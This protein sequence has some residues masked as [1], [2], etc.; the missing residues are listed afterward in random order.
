MIKNSILKYSNLS[1]FDQRE[2]VFKSIKKINIKTPKLFKSTKFFGKKNEETKENIMNLFCKTMSS[3]YSLDKSSS[4]L[5]LLDYFENDKQKKSNI[6]HKFKSIKRNSNIKNEIENNNNKT[7]KINKTSNNFYLTE[8]SPI[9]SRNKPKIKKLSEL[10]NQEKGQKDDLNIDKLLLIKTYRNNENNKMKISDCSDNKNRTY[11]K[12]NKNNFDMKIEEN[13]DKHLINCKISK[14]ISNRQP[15]V[16]DFIKKTQELKIHSYTAK[17]KKERAIRLEEG[18]LNQIEFY[19][20]T[21]NSLQ[22]AQKLLDVQFVNKIS[23]YTRFVMSKRERELVKSSILIQEIINHRKDLEHIKNKINKIEFEK[24]NILKW[25][26]FMIQI[27]EKR[28][29]LPAHYKTIIEKIRE[30]RASG[31][32]PTKKDEKKEKNKAKV[33]RKTSLSKFDNTSNNNKDNYNDS[34]NNKDRNL[35]DNNNETN[36][37]NRKEEYERLMNYKNS[38]IFQTPE[39]FQERLSSFEKENITLITYYNE[40]YHQLFGYKKELKLLKKDEVII[41]A[42]NCKIKEKEKELKEIKEIIEEKTKLISDFKMKQKNLEIEFK[43]ERDKSKSNRIGKISET[44]IKINEEKINSKEIRN[45]LLYRKINN[46]FEICKIVG[47][48][49]KFAYFILNLVNKKIYTKEKE[50]TLMLEFIEQTVDYLIN[51]F[52]YHLKKNEEIQEL[53]KKVKSDIEKEHKLEKA[54]LQMMIDFQKIT[55]LKEKVEKR[56]NKIYFLPLKKIDLSNYKIKTERKIT[57]KYLNRIPGIEDYLYN[58][59]NTGPE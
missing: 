14:F 8:A 56:S 50:M 9:K 53:I 58:E 27:K 1:L 18:Y 37:M 59:N 5:P 31:R 3:F 36:Q 40:L 42:R 13:E 23:D 43:K 26:Y 32:Q 29:V 34:N 4:V 10:L 51:F 49:Q 39:E 17:T 57:D 44:S 54:R 33:K 16:K 25:I 15:T 11:R 24:N 38:L 47:S 52:K 30:K 12:N 55:K 19:Q 6:S 2:K 28:L 22:S 20:D 45:T 46:I 7:D 41:E 21:V 35:S 48:K